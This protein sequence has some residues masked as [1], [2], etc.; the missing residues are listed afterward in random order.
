[1]DTSNRV[2]TPNLAPTSKKIANDSETPASN[3]NLDTGDQ[4]SKIYEKFQEFVNRL[5]S[6]QCGEFKIK[7]NAHVH[8]VIRFA[9]EFSKENKPPLTLRSNPGDYSHP[10]HAPFVY[11]YPTPNEIRDF[12]PLN[13]VTE[14]FSYSPSERE[15]STENSQFFKIIYAG[16]GQDPLLFVESTKK[17]FLNLKTFGTILNRRIIAL[18]N[19]RH[20]QN[21]IAAKIERNQTYIQIAVVA[22]PL[23]IGC[24]FYG[25]NIGAARK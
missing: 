11:E 7:C 6:K 18:E 13:L 24:L 16:Q 5:N 20:E 25:L 1:M 14:T 17:N 23:F 3:I 4:I 19:I 2:S 12:K 10:S 22:L 15:I 9:L 21:L 8:T